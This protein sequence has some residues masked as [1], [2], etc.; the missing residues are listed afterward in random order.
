MPSTKL[1]TL[2]GHL[3]PVQLLSRSG[4]C[5]PTPSRS[6]PPLPKRK[7]PEFCKRDF[8]GVSRFCLLPF[9]FREGRR[10]TRRGR[11]SE[12]RQQQ[13]LSDRGQDSR[14]KDDTDSEI[15]FKIV[16]TG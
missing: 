12:Y 5:E 6:S 16:L 10:G 2:L 1:E 15:A 4:C 13:W 9:L 8:N 14:G 7:G 11:L 3:G